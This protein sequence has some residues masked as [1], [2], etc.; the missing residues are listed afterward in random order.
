MSLKIRGLLAVSIGVVLG[1]SLSLGSVV[2]ADRDLKASSSLPWD[3]A[4]L[5]AE[6]LERVKRDYVDNVDDA[7]LIE[8]A[9]RGMSP[10]SIPIPPTS[11]PR[12]TRRSG[13]ARPAT[14]PASGWR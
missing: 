8:A 13:S 9:I 7:E 5:L 6:V 3:E 4:R 11:T 1:L 12:N 2:L 14:T 10:I